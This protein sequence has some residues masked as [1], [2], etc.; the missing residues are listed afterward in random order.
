MADVWSATKKAL[1]DIFNVG[2]SG[3]IVGV[4]DLIAYWVWYKWIR[5]KQDPVKDML[6]AQIE[7]SS[8]YHLY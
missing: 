6:R 7:D 1:W 8:T 2:F 4:M 5:D 3:W